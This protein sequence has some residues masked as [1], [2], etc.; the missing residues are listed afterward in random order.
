MTQYDYLRGLS[1]F[2]YI[3]Q[4]WYFNYLALFRDRQ[5]TVRSPDLVGCVSEA[6][7]ASPKTCYSNVSIL[8]AANS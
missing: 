8:W 7:N 6:R 3:L 1:R 5:D 4:F 2:T